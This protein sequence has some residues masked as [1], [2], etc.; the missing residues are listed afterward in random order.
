MQGT[1]RS[2]LVTKN[3][4]FHSVDCYKAFY[5]GA[6]FSLALGILCDQYYS[7]NDSLSAFSLCKRYQYVL[8]FQLY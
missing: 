5:F 6:L 4:Q 3:V 1:E 2:T 8:K 7:C